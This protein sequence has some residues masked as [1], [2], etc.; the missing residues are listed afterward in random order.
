[1]PDATHARGHTVAKVEYERRVL[2]FFRSAF[3]RD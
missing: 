2:E 3:Q 1:V